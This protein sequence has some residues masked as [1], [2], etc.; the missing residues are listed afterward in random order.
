MRSFVVPVVLFW[1]TI[2]RGRPT[3]S[4]QDID[5]TQRVFEAGET[6]QIPLLDHL[7]IGDGSY[8]SLKALG[9]VCS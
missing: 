2:I 7:V 6:L 4:G 3:P 5:I 1:P 8:V 9:F